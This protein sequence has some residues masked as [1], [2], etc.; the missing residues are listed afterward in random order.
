MYPTV[1]ISLRTL[2]AYHQSHRTCPRFGIQAQ[3]KTLAFLHDIP[4][5][6]YLNMQF[7]VAYDIYLEIRHCVQQ[8]LQAPLG[9]DTPNWCLLNSCPACF[10]K[11]RDEPKLEFDWLISIDGNNSLKRWDSTIY[12]NTPR[13]DSRWARSDYWVEPKAVDRFQN[14]IASHVDDWQD[15]PVEVNPSQSFSF[16]DES[17]IFIAAC[18]HRF[19][20]VACDMLRSGELAK[21]PLALIDKLLGV[22]GPNGGCAYD[23]GCAFSKTLSS[24][25]LAS[26]VNNLGFRMMLHWHLLYIPGTGHSE[27]EGCE[28]IFSASNKLARSTR[29]ASPFHRH[30]SIEEH[31]SFWDKDKYAV[32][33]NFLWNHYREALKVITTLTVELTIIKAEL[34]LTDDDFPRFLHEECNYLESLKE[35]PVKDNLCIRYVEEL[36]AHMEIQLSIDV[37]WEI[38]GKEYKHFKDEAS[39][40]KYHTALDELERLIVMRFE[41]SKL[42]LS[43]TGY[44]LRQQISKALQRCSETIRKAITRYNVQA[45]ALNPPR[46]NILWKDIADYSFIAEFDLLRHSRTDIGSN[47]WAKPVHREATT[48]NFKLLRASGIIH[49]L[50]ISDPLLGRELKR[51]WCSRAA[52][53]A[54]HSY[55]LDQIAGL[56]GFSGVNTVGIRLELTANAHVLNAGHISVP[57][58]D[59]DDVLAIIR[60]DYDNMEAI[61]REED[62]AA[63]QD[64]ADY[65]HSIID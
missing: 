47:D 35:L 50:L 1:A 61:D 4:Y 16:F 12:G 43:G 2:A 53:N 60:S 23:I 64:M 48:K 37:W 51:Q 62:K 65:L 52:I 22:Y 13:V 5:R 59:R 41:L 33:S 26:Q 34:Q 3:C 55:R 25:S 31:F 24:S 27:G 58:E 36:V 42:S 44:K 19:V 46:P 8:R 54:V 6:L 28:H 10:Y 38:G 40:S 11:L 20:L 7:S 49:D 57:Q 15:E 21:Y 32:L 29:H 63:T 14:E 56:T 9:R 18:R 45:A 17:R 39:L 30:Q